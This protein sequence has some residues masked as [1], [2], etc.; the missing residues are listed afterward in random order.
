[1][2]AIAV[3]IISGEIAS[4][5]SEAPIRSIV[6]WAAQQDGGV[7]GEVVHRALSVYEAVVPGPAP[8]HDEGGTGCA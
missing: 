2:I 4:S 7:G 6:V 1:L 8:L 3:A 5:P